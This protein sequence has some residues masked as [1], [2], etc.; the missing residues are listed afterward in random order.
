MT[1][2]ELIVRALQAS[3]DQAAAQEFGGG[4]GM[5]KADVAVHDGKRLS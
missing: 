2:N 4:P 3:V 1:L 5:V